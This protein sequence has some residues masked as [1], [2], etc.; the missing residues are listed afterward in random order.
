MST[1]TLGRRTTTALLVAVLAAALA[2]PASAAP[3]VSMGEAMNGKV[4]NVKLGSLVSVMLHSTYWSAASLPKASLLRPLGSAVTTPIMPGAK[5]PA[6]C[7]IAGSGCGTVLWRFT[8]VRVGTARFV[9]SRTS[10]GEAMR[11][12]A[13]Q[14]HYRVTI[15]I[16][17]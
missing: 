6:R 16:V 8:A 10:C 3:S 12:T 11:C 1:C 5:A 13:A 14:G 17:K 15:R 7:R 4:V 9:A 2:L